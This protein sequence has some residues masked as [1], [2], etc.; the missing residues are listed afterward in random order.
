MT[1]S[2]ELDSFWTSSKPGH[3]AATVAMRDLGLVTDAGNG[4][5]GDM[6]GDRIQGLLDILTPIFTAQ[7]AEG[8]DPNVTPSD[9]YTNEFLDP[10]ISLGF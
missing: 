5:V 10:S 6:D 1:S 2:R 9:L 7:G 4:F 3:A 8:F